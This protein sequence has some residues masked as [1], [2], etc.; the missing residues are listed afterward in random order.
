MLSCLLHP[1]IIFI[2]P[3]ERSDADLIDVV[4]ARIGVIDIGASDIPLS[5]DGSVILIDP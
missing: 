4:V 5:G 3:Y 2:F 1:I